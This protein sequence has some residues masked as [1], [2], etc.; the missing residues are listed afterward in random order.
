MPDVTR[1]CDS[2]H[3]KAGLSLQ[4]I[5]HHFFSLHSCINKRNIS[6]PNV[7]SYVLLYVIIC[8][9]IV[10][11]DKMLFGYFMN[12]LI[13]ANVSRSLIHECTISLWFLRVILRVL[14]LEISVYNVYIQCDTASTRKKSGSSH[15]TSHPLKWEYTVIQFRT[16]ITYFKIK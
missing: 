14:K 15:I 9:Y 7:M 2:L 13:L 12:K 1:T 3:I 5:G 4:S 11:N 6:I 10:L 16:F 8:A